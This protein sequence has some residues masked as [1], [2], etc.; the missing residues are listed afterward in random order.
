MVFSF[1]PTNPPALI[2]P[3]LWGI[4][5]VTMEEARQKHKGAMW[6]HGTSHTS[7]YWSVVLAVVMFAHVAL[8][9]GAIYTNPS[10]LCL[11]RNYRLCPIPQ[12]HSTRWNSCSLPQRF[13]LYPA[14]HWLQPAESSPA[15]PHPTPQTNSYQFKM[16]FVSSLSTKFKLPESWSVPWSTFISAALHL[17][18][19]FSLRTLYMIIECKG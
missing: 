8:A 18:H 16:A 10:P 9:F 13:P 2:K 11:P 17:F 7:R 6:W 4:P 1:F 19:K 12:I 14:V 15:S 3:W 5:L